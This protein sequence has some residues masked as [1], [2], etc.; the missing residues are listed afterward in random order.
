M[1]EKMTSISKYRRPNCEDLLELYKFWAI[2][3]E[4]LKVDVIQKF[5]SST[6]SGFEFCKH[7]INIKWNKL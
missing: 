2:S 3:I 6:D 5:L 7:F 1:T 4:D